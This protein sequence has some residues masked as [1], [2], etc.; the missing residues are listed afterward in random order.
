MKNICIFLLL[1]SI[2]SFSQNKVKGFS[3]LSSPEKCWV[4]FHLFKA[5]KAMII[6]KE[7]IHVSDSINKT[8]ILDKDKNGGQVDAFKHSYWLARLSQSIGKNAAIK[9][10]KAHEKGNYKTYKKGKLED[11][12][13][14]DK[15]SSDMDLFNN[16]VGAKIGI[17]NYNSSKEKIIEIIISEI[18][19]GKMKIIKKDSNGNF[20]TCEGVIISKEVL[21]STWENN[22]CLVSSNAK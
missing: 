19:E 13:L 22:K 2:N 16:Q 6:S 21:K 20:L 17:K 3:K 9:L 18:K 5:K 10:G 14:P 12:F 7:A 8:N 11:G 15:L 1:F 4:V